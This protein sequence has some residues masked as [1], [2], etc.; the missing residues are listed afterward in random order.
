MER[1]RCKLAGSGT[2]SARSM[3]VAAR[4]I[5]Y[6]LGYKHEAAV[7]AANKRTNQVR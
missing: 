2:E 1:Q 7:F 5:G 3:V 6:K 4:A